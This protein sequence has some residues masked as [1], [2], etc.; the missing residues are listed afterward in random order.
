M[1]L[2]DENA[3]VSHRHSV[4]TGR[5]FQCYFPLQPAVTRRQRHQHTVSQTSVGGQRIIA[6][7][8]N[9]VPGTRREQS[10]GGEHQGC[11]TYRES[12][13]PLCFLGMLA[14]VTNQRLFVRRVFMPICGKQQV[15]FLAHIKMRM[16]A[17]LVV[18]TNTE[19]RLGVKSQH[20]TVRRAV[21]QPDRSVKPGIVEKAAPTGEV[22][23]PDSAFVLRPEDLRTAA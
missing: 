14:H 6:T 22:L 10:V 21:Q 7:F 20:F 16:G 11:E 1:R 18:G 3:P 2:A 12:A 5:T 8:I 19:Y 9:N 13:S 4:V 17:A 15:S 23:I